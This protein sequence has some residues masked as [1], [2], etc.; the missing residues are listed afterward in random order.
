MAAKPEAYLKLIKNNT[1][2]AEHMRALS[3]SIFGEPVRP[4]SQ[5][6]MKVIKLFSEKP[7]QKRPEIADYYF[8]VNEVEKL[9]AHLRKYR[10]FK[11]DHAE[12]KEYNEHKRLARGK[13][14][15][16]PPPFRNKTD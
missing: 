11:D 14:K 8:T 2:Y 9:M 7:L 13:T 1:V 3:N 16:V 5:K 6:S 15:W 4:V 12:F 10:L